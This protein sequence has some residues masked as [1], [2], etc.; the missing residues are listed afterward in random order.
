MAKRIFSIN[1]FG[2]GGDFVA[3]N[4]DQL[5]EAIRSNV[6]RLTYVSDKKIA[7]AWDG[8]ETC[9]FSQARSG[10]W[11]VKAK[12]VDVTKDRK[13]EI[14]KNRM[15]SEAKKIASD[16]VANGV[17]NTNRLAQLKSR[18]DRLGFTL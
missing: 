17:L 14:I 15:E 18:A 13:L 6:N 8:K 11:E 5:E 12:I 10:K 7:E 2:F 1:V 9:I 16:F 4:K 3:Y